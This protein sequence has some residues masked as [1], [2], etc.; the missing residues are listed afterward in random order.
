MTNKTVFEMTADELNEY[1]MQC[2]MDEMDFAEAT[3][4]A[5]L[6]GKEAL[7]GA[8]TERFPRFA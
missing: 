5:Y 7:E 2:D 8:P 4:Q 1:V 3:E 6:E